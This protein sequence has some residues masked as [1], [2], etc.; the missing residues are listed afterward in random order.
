MSKINTGSESCRTTVQNVDS[1]SAI[2]SSLIEIEG[3]V[4]SPSKCKSKIFSYSVQIGLA[5]E[6]PNHLVISASVAPKASH[7]A[8]G[9]AGN[10]GNAGTKNAPHAD[11]LI[12]TIIIKFQTPSNEKIFGLGVQYSVRN[13]KGLVVPVLSSEQGIGRGLEP[14]TKL[15]NALRD[16]GGTNHYPTGI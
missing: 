4:V 12:N 9:N 11:A 2:S 5:P 15:L 10:A 16:S 8:A 7:D 1:V 6:S 3:R 14:L 13:L